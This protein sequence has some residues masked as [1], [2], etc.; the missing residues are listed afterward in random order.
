MNPILWK[1]FTGQLSVVLLG[2]LLITITL[3][4]PGIIIALNC[5]GELRVGDFGILPPEDERLTLEEALHTYTTGGIYANFLENELGLIEPGKLADLVILD[6]DLYDIDTEEIPKVRVRKT[7]FET[8]F[9]T[10]IG[11]LSDEC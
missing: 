8:D 4:D 3:V 2:L 11:G 6:R 10:T 1:L 9:G 5:E 7:V